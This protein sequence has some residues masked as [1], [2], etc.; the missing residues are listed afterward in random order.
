MSIKLLKAISLSDSVLNHKLIEMERLKYLLRL[1]IFY[2]IM[3]LIFALFTAPTQFNCSK[4][5]TLNIKF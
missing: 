3:L 1:K 5:D 4:V 2:S